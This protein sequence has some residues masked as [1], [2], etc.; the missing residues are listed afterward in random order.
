MRGQCFVR[1]LLDA[2]ENFAASMA[3]V[4]VDGHFSD[5]ILT[6]EEIERCLSDAL[7]RMSISIRV[8]HPTHGLTRGRRIDQLR[9]G[10]DDSL[11]ICSH[12]TDGSDM[13]CLGTLGFV[14]HDQYRLAE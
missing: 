7:A 1:E 2:V 5:F 14:T 10:G 13:D 6:A 3:L 8:V 12:E 11:F 9:D 4:F